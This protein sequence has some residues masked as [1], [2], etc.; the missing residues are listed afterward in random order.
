MLRFIFLNCRRFVNL[1]EDGSQMVQKFQAD[2]RHVKPA[3]L[4]KNNIHA[5]PWSRFR[6]FEHF[7]ALANFPTNQMINVNTI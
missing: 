7:L 6:D 2:G 4:Q 1:E 5:P 3:P